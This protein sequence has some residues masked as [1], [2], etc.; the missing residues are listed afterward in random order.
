M[1]IAADLALALDPVLLAERAGLEPDPWQRDVL[2]STAPRMLLNC[3]RQSG[4]S[5]MAAV[6]AAH[7][8]VYEPGSLTLLLSP[9]QRQS[10][11]LF[12]RSLAVYRAL[13]RPVPADSETALTLTLENGSRIVSLPG[14]EATIRG[15]SGVGLLLVDE[16]ARVPTDLYMATRPMLA[17]SGGRLV[18][19]STPFGTRG[20][21]YEAWRS[22]EAWERYE[23]PATDC[24]RIS[25]EFLEEE[26]R[27]IG[28][29]WF[30]QEYGCR[31][32]DAQSAAFRREDI[33]RAFEEEVDAWTL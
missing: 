11:E 3:S 18:A 2:R 28:D 12:K 26:R 24:P 19:L 15:Y 22:D 9:G 1:A 32:L 31:F 29:W 33:D 30:D 20:W 10:G 23:V 25:P 21:W 7:T 5:T 27:T 17:V 16:A 14:K 6:L 8:A 4:K 13:G